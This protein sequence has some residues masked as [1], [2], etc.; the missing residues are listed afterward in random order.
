M[1]DDDP[2]QTAY[3]PPRIWTYQV[4]R[5]R[6]CLDDF[7]EHKDKLRDCYNFCVDAY[8]HN[9][10]SLERALLDNHDQ[11]QL[12]FSQQVAK[13]P[14]LRNGRK[15]HGS[16]ELTARKFGIEELLRSW[17]APPSGSIDI[18]TLSA[19]FSLVEFAG[20]AYIANFTLQRS[21]EVAALRAD[22]LVWEQDPVV[23]RIAIICGETTKTDPDSDARWPTSPSVSVAV[24]AMTTVARMRMRCAQ[25]NPLAACSEY[26]VENPFLA[27]SAFEPWSC[28][29]VRR[30]Y[31]TRP[32][33]QTYQEGLIQFPRLFD[34]EKLRI[35][36]EDMQIALRFTPNLEKKEWFKVGSIWPLAYHQLRRTTGINMFASG[37][38]SDTSIQ[39]IMK[40]L[41]LLQSHYY[42]RN[43]SRVRFN[44]EAERA[45]VAAR[46]EVMG[47]QIEAVVE[48]HYVSPLGEKR[49]DEIVVHLVA[50]KDSTKLAKAGRQGLVSF[51]DIRLGGCTKKGHCE[52]GG[53]ESVARCAGGDEGKPCREVLYDKRKRESVARQLASAERRLEKLAPDT[54]LARALQSEVRGFRNYLDATRD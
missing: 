24:D 7:L 14:G 39:V 26:D 28:F 6:K 54:P 38:L 45:V 3:I 1:E 51:R 17:V 44:D 13:Q 33:P 48:D 47:R 20:H 35:T 15:F 5:L 34:Q 37:I 9:F 53:V 23:G 52:Y 21:K 32:T 2:V 40:H 25:A 22:C 10:G 27:H 29:P 8:A 43:F 36:E 46:Y 30:P 16:F 42:L 41:T 19:Y 4:L 12:P 50:V 31:A 18:R 11:K 49:K